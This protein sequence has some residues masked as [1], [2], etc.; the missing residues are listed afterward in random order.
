MAS[1][2]MITTVTSSSTNVNPRRFIILLYHARSELAPHD[3]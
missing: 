3:V 1:M 2:A